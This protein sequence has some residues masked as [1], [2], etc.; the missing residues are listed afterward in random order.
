MNECASRTIDN[1][2]NENRL[3]AA[4][5]FDFDPIFV[6]VF[7]ADNVIQSNEKLLSHRNNDDNGKTL[8]DPRE[9]VGECFEFL[10]LLLLAR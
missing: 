7:C 5:W 3:H 8:T 6:E 2:P 10:L 1:T 9:I 4:G